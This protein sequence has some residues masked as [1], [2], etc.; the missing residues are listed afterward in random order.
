MDGDLERRIDELEKC[1]AEYKVLARRSQSRE[2]R[3]NSLTLAAE[4]EALAAQLRQQLAKNALQGPR[5]RH[6][7]R[8]S[9]HDTGT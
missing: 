8:K 4:L 2:I 1:A 7:G 3:E 6:P 9:G 5:L